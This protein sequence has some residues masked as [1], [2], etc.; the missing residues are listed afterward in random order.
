[1]SETS[2]HD[3]S[4]VHEA[5]APPSG[6]ASPS[7]DVRESLR[8]VIRAE[9]RDAEANRSRNLAA[10]LIV[11]A[12]GVAA[13]A[14]QPVRSPTQYGR[15]SAVL[16]EG[17]FL[18]VA[19]VT[20]QVSA[21]R[22][23]QGRRSLTPSRRLRGEGNRRGEG[24]GW[25]PAGWFLF[26]APLALYVGI[27]LSC[28][29]EFRRLSSGFQLYATP[30]SHVVLAAWVIAVLT[31][32]VAVVTIA[33][34]WLTAR[35]ARPQGIGPE[36]RES[37]SRTLPARATEVSRR[38]APGT[39]AM[40]RPDD[41]TGSRESEGTRREAAA[42]TPLVLA[43]SGGGL[44]SASFCLGGFNAVQLRPDVTKVDALVA[45]SGGGYAASA[46]TLTR[47]FAGN[48]DA[49]NPPVPPEPL[50]GVEEVYALPSPELA[51]LRRNSRYLFQPPW[52]TV[53]GVWQLV[54]GAL[55]N[56]FIFVMALLVFAWLLGWYWAAVG[57]VRRLGTASPR[58]V[59]STWHHWQW[60]VSSFLWIL[61]LAVIAVLLFVQILRR[62]SE[63][64]APSSVPWARGLATA[65]RAL[66]GLV[67]ALVLMPALV[68]GLSRAAYANEPTAL[69]A[70]GIVALGLTK[71]S[72]CQTA[73][74]RSADAAHVSAV[75]RAALSGQPESASYGACGASGTL[76]FDPAQ[77]DTYN[78][79]VAIASVGGAP[80]GSSGG[81]LVSIL[82]ILAA[83]LGSLRRAFTAVGTS[84]GGRFAAVRRWLLLRLPLAAVSLVA[85]WLLLLWSYR[86]AVNGPAQSG[87]L[88]ALLILGALVV[89]L[90]NPNLTSIHEFYRERLSSAFAV[91]RD[92][93][94]P[95]VARNLPYSAAYKL[96]ELEPAPELVL[97]TTANINDQKVVPTR[98]FGVPL[99][100]SSQ[101]VRL[102][103]G[104]LVPDLGYQATAA[105]EQD[106]RGPL[107]TVMAASAMSGAAVSPMMGR[108]GGKVA[109]FR[110]LLT[111]FNVRLGVWVMN[112]RWPL[113][114]PAP[115]WWAPMATQPRFHQLF[116]EAFGSTTI[117]DR[118]VYLT[119]GGHLDNLG[120]VE[121]VRRLPNRVLA[122]SASN[123]APGSWQD[124]GAAVS[125]LR[126][127][128]NI[129]LKVVGRD[130]QDTWMRLEAPMPED[131]DGTIDVLVVRASLTNQ[132]WPLDDTGGDGAAGPAGA[133]GAA[134]AAPPAY[135]PVDQRMPID[136]RS[137]ATRDATFPRTST[138]RQDFGDLEFESYRRLGRYLVDRALWQ[139]PGFFT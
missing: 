14:S 138:G 49:P 84:M 112:P 71:E 11:L 105:V 58:L 27:V 10:I 29:I 18:L 127:D 139:N 45:V 104:G 16:L 12:V 36:G 107:L 114:E 86:Y 55:I 8:E 60:W 13:I 126:S 39:S 111:L 106:P 40:V 66:I 122:M 67:L 37:E 90:M 136:V 100:F 26:L 109:P 72:A 42:E 6:E 102:E 41:P 20:L 103:S 75:R 132:D 118:W 76:V 113:G 47:S 88:A 9:S 96:S 7:P 51:Y 23:V 95:R 38:V 135:P 85:L 70:K 129:D 128:L 97:C 44:R 63:V 19:F 131:P 101:L 25:R 15:L 120:L 78:R 91:G 125:V 56:L 124:V 121:A 33:A 35:L 119:D 24:R 3:E 61:A 92:N 28:R 98:R 81:K 73:I 123:D 117:D 116:S 57:L 22:L 2:G 1:M 54:G 115:P 80:S 68:V 133:A 134:G 93:A 62:N 53:T 137:F 59:F 74:G 64:K 4:Y 43:F 83:A 99:T 69:V 87:V 94:A 82:V 50:P 21:G 79:H 48:A 32:A 77:P 31:V 130:E 5:P 52:R 89:Q 110:L 46:I 65:S 17:V 108:M 30:R 34:A